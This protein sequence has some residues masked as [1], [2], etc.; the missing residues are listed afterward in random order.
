MT[1][2]LDDQE[3]AAAVAG[4][5]LAPEGDEHLRSCLDCNRRVA[6]LRRLIEGRRAAVTDGEPDGEAV[7]AAVLARIA[8]PAGAAA[9]Q[10]TAT[11]TAARLG[12]SWR[13]MKSSPRSM[14]CWTTTRSPASK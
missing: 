11:A 6:A 10:A 14:R 2:H 3:I 12:T 8:E 9:G 13:W 1:R 5:G 4:L 7:R